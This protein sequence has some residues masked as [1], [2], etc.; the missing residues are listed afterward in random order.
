LSEVRHDAI[1]VLTLARPEARN[2]LSL[3]MLLALQS[4]IDRLSGDRDVCAVV[5][6]ATGPAFCAGHD[7]KELTAHRR[8]D[9]RGRAFYTLTMARCAAVMTSIMRSPKPFIAA[10]EGVA[11]A[12]G[13]QL[14]ATS[15]LAVAGEAAKFATPGVDIGLFCSTPMVALSR[16]VPRKRAMEMLLLG[17]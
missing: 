11:T 2:S 1:A 9:D 16:N 7:L 4:A 15:D 14:V 12:A 10:V 13:C 8:D 5:L 6:A 3:D 17:D